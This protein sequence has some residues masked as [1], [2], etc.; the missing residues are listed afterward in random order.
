MPSPEQRPALDWLADAIPLPASVLRADGVLVWSNAAWG[1][2]DD[3]DKH[4]DNDPMLAVATRLGAAAAD[5]ARIA[6]GLRDVLAGRMAR[7]TIE[8]ATVGAAT[9]QWL[10]LFASAPWPGNATHTEI[11]LVRQDITAR[12]RAEAELAEREAHLRSVLETVP[13][14]VIVIDETGR[15]DQ[16]SARAERQFGFSAAEVMGRNVS[17]LMP[18]AYADGHDG[19]IRR[20]LETGEARIIGTGRIVVGQRKDGSTFPMELQVGEATR[21]GKR[22]FTGFI[23]DLTEKQ[24]TEAR[25]QELHADFLHESRL[26]SL[27]EMAAQLAHELNQPLAATANYLKAALMLLERGADTDAARLRQ[28]VELAERQTVRAGDIIRR[29]RE[30]VTRGRTETRTESIAR[31]VEEASALALVGARQHG[32]DSR[33][34]VAPGLPAVLVDRVQ[35]QQVLLNLMRNAMEAMDNATQRTLHVRAGLVDGAV[36]VSVSD[37]GCGISPAVA[38]H[39]FQPF[40]T[41]KADGMGIGLSTCRAIVEAHG[42]RLWWE[43]APGGGT[44][45]HFTLPLADTG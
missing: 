45:F 39:L 29:L 4:T 44:V 24:A 31:L 19:H 9:R 14:A 40:V 8:F 26:H 13:D 7:F 16:F 32:V 34:D 3:A 37:T 5:A 21:G 33:I 43:P 1:P 30:F 42:G 11:L 27:G 18:K 25:M 41:T 20:Y 36:R 22:L 2:P 12:M 15:I 17:M 23:R 35:I 38:A 28:A 10:R 6:Q